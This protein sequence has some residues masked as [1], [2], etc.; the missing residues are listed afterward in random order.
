AKLQSSQAATDRNAQQGL[1]VAGMAQQ[2]AL[3]AMM[4]RGNM[5][6][7][8]R[9]Q[10]FSQQAQ[11]AAAQDAINSFNTANQNTMG[12]NNATM[13]YNAAVGNRDARQGINNANVDLSNTAQMHNK[14]TIPSTSF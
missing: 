14:F 11:I 5:S 8:M 3:Q 12:W 1:D 13:G 4:E 10:D 9:G 6:G 7:Q 2:R